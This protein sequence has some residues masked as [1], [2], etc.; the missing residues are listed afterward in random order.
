MPNKRSRRNKT[1]KFHCPY[2]QRRLW[3]V[4]SPKYYVF[5]NGK[6]EM[7]EGLNLSGKNAGLLAAQQSTCLDTNVW[8]EE[9]FC[10]EDGK[11]WMHLVRA[12]SGELS[13]R[14]AQQKDWKRTVKTVDPDMPKH[15]CSEYSNRMSRRAN[16]NLLRGNY[17]M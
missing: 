5:Y 10:E 3:R 16:L 9:F 2:C 15:A 8:I 14:L 4:G 6:H 1:P 7:K 12:E 13:V 11:V 17:A